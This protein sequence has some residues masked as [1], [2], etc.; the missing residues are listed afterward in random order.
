MEGG[1]TMLKRGHLI[2]TWNS[3]KKEVHSPLTRE[4]DRKEKKEK[5]KRKVAMQ[6]LLL[7]FSAFQGRKE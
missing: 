6:R 5:E 2:L 4:E 1:P 7:L 3:N